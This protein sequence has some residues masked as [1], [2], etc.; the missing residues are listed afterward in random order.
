M[1][2]IISRQIITD[3]RIAKAIWVSFFVIATTFGAY[4]RIPLPFTPVPITLQTFF[5]LLSGA[6]MG[7]KLGGFSQFLYFLLGGI[8]LPLFTNTG[9]LWGPTG[10]YIFGFILASWLVGYL[11]E[12]EWKVFYA[13]LL[14][15]LVLL[16]SG[17]LILSLFVGGLKNAVVLGVLPFI[18]GDLIKIFA[19][20]PVI[21]LIKKM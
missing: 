20:L 14:G 19:A 21:K 6:V 10:G 16:F 13:L 5:V 8:G 17:M 12:K 11:I 2:T 1:E 7:K 15:D 9:A 4:V 3:K 18:V